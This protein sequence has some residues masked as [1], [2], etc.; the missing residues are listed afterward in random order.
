M[1]LLLKMSP[2]HIN[3]LRGNDHMNTPKKTHLIGNSTIIIHSP[4]VAMTSEERAEWFK[5]E[6]EKGNPVLKEIAAS[7]DRC[8]TG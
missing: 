5:L 8:Y 1:A 6:W 7:V 2:L 4:L 3:Q